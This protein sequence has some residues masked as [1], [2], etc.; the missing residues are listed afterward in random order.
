MVTGGHFVKINVTK[1]IL[2]FMKKKIVS[3]LFHLM[4]LMTNILGGNVIL[5]LQ[6]SY[7]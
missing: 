3:V 5:V 7:Y 6:I 2:F 4:L 1:Y